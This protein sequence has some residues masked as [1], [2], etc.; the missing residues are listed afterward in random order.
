MARHLPSS[1][2]PPLPVHTR[3]S[4]PCCPPHYC[5]QSHSFVLVIR[6]H[7]SPS[8]QAPPGCREGP[9][10]LS[11]RRRADSRRPPRQGRDTGLRISAVGIYA[12]RLT[13]SIVYFCW[14]WPSTPRAQRKPVPWVCSANPPRPR[15]VVVMSEIGLCQDPPRIDRTTPFFSGPCGFRSGA[16]W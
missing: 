15:A 10:Y 14:D 1:V 4:D 12:H 7:G 16:C 6:F 2:A 3:S 5:R 13:M 11:G 9:I 8:R